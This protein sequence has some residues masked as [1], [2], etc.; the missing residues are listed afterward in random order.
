MFTEPDHDAVKRP[1]IGDCRRGSADLA[2]WMSFRGA[3][4]CVARYALLA[5]RVGGA[6][7]FTARRSSGRATSEPERDHCA[8][9]WSGRL[10]VCQAM[11]S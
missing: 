9:G 1:G 3:S 5:H 8:S 6:D 2:R 4:I 11:V 10:T 7:V